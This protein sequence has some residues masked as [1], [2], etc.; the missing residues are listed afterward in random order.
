MNFSEDLAQ[1]LAAVHIHSPAAFTFAG[2]AMQVTPGPVQQIPG[3]PSHPLPQSPLIRDLQA[4]L[5][6]R[7]YS[8]RLGDAEISASAPDSDF[9]QRLSAAN[10]TTL[11]WESGWTIYSTGAR[12]EV[13]VQKG[14]R[15]RSAV[16]GEFTGCAVPGQ[17]PQPGAS[18]NLLVARECSVAQPGFYFAYGSTLSDL[19][20][21]FMLLRFYFHSTAKGAPDLVEY[22]T[23]QLN[24]Y[25]IPFGMKTLAD[26]TLYTRTDAT[27]LYTARR[28]HDIV[29]R[30]ATRIDAPV[31]AGL[32][33]AT[34][35]FTLQLCP[36][37]GLAEE[38]HT[39]ESFGMNR[40]RLTAEGIVDAWMGGD[41]SL[42]SC[43]RTVAARFAA[44]AI[45]IN[46][47]YLSPGS[48]PLAG[49]AEEVEFTHV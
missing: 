16:P 30:I 37:V 22:L 8:H 3:Y 43:Q 31:D 40:C 15:Q 41:Q 13:Y 7:C 38:P 14:D 10:R 44:S 18:V 25:Q 46:Q 49:I 19:W 42:A 28:H 5:Y 48:A 11:R 9:V 45:D 47:P 39:G 33:S 29:R 24:R 2:E 23:R 6:G 36:G 1:V 21:E 26:P 17:P 35:L 12:G 27:V 34:P 32:R 4:A 20:D